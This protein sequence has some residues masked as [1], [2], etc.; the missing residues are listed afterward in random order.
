MDN[1]PNATLEGIRLLKEWSNVLLVVQTGVIGFIGQA[2][3]ANEGKHAYCAAIIC[4]ICF[5]ISILGAANLLGS[6]PKLAAASATFTD[7]YSQRGNL[8]VPIGVS[9]AIQGLFFAVGIIAFAFFAVLR[10]G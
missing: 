7:F 9:A 5:V 1:G 6:L 8:C 4:I 3:K 10:N 2:L